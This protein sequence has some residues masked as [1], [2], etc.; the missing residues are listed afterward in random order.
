MS[1]V[2]RCGEPGCQGGKPRPQCTHIGC[3][4]TGIARGLCARHYA[5]A[6]KAERLPT[7]PVQSV[8]LNVFDDTGG[9]CAARPGPCKELVCRYH[10]GNERWAPERLQEPCV[11]RLASAGPMTLEEIGLAMGLTRERVRQI[12]VEA[13][14]KLEGVAV[15]QLGLEGR[16]RSRR[17]KVPPRLPP[18]ERWTA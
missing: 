18:Q 3:G 1:S 6:R 16:R 10:L 7:S 12:E 2:C 11:L 5:Q 15:S 4:R 8:R 9:A 17:A 14:R 13:L